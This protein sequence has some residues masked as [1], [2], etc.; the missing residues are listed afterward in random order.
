MVVRRTVLLALAAAAVIAAAC[1]PSTG[2]VSSGQPT[3]ATSAPT[4]PATSPGPG[5]DPLIPYSPPPREITDR[6]TGWAGDTIAAPNSAGGTMHVT[7]VSTA[8]GP[9]VGPDGRP[10]SV[11]FTI[12]NAD[13][14]AWSG[15]PGGFVTFTD[16]S[17][18]V[19]QPIPTPG[20]SD[21]HPHPERYGVS[22]LDLHKPRTI[23]PGK[24]ISGVS[25]FRVQGGYRPTTIAISFDKGVTWAS[26]LTSF[27][28]S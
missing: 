9:V 17:G 5:P 16:A 3:T 26:W 14:P 4:S 23:G 2:S 7:L 28:P 20:E 8:I 11:W 22:N 13:G 21:L 25:L 24:A 12:E 19:L 15:F 10:F 1:E 27:G 6:T 18:V